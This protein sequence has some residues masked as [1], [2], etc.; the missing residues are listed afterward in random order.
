M[1]VVREDHISIYVNTGGYMARPP[2]GRTNA[3]VGEKVYARHVPQS[4]K[5]VVRLDEDTEEKWS[6]SG[7]GWQQ[8]KLKKAL[9]AG[10]IDK[11]EYE[12]LLAFTSLYNQYAMARDHYGYPLNGPDP[13][14]LPFIEKDWYDFRSSVKTYDRMK[15]RVKK[16][17]E[18]L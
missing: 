12:R 1:P 10:R 16:V 4:T 15:E 3:R 17:T 11:A 9:K 2:K 8:S 6:T 7:Q 5:V 14:Y 13:Y 18:G